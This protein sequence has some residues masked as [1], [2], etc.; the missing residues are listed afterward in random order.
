[1]GRSWIRLKS[2]DESLNVSIMQPG[3]CLRWSRL[4]GWSVCSATRVSHS[5]MLTAV[6]N[7]N[8][9]R[10][11]P[12]NQIHSIWSTMKNICKFSTGRILE[13]K[14]KT[15]YKPPKEYYIK[16]GLIPSDERLNTTVNFDLYLQLYDEMLEELRHQYTEQLTITEG[17]GLLDR[18]KVV[19]D[20]GRQV[21]LP[22]LAQI[23]LK[24][25]SDRIDR[26]DFKL[27]NIYQ[28][29]LYII[30]LKNNFQYIRE[31]KKAIHESGMNLY[32]QQEG[33]QLICPIPS[34]VFH[35]EK[36][37][38]DLEDNPEDLPVRRRLHNILLIPPTPHRVPWT[39]RVRLCKAAEEL[40]KVK[41]DEFRWKRDQICSSHKYHCEQNDLPEHFHRGTRLKLFAIHQDFIKEAEELMTARQR[42]LMPGHY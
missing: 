5:S 14:L 16:C 31:V 19:T 2:Y 8:R 12:E 18:I 33:V 9:A 39:E 3:P 41:C 26:G 30:D 27:R 42:E 17:G 7:D 29:Y 25:N 35:V 22:Q 37:K 40:M 24:E 23:T 38:H 32:P 34:E 20:D 21:R 4:C 1:M 36:I 11:S 28:E 15:R 6:T 13:R 10:C